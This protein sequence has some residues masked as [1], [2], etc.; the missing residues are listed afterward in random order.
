MSYISGTGNGIAFAC[1]GN[2]DAV[3]A[4]LSTVIGMI[5][6]LDFSRFRSHPPK[7]SFFMLTSSDQNHFYRTCL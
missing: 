2:Y 1:F 5:E 6:S 7:W 4:A 3:S